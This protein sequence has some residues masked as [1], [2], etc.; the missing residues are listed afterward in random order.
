MVPP[1]AGESEVGALSMIMADDVYLR[2]SGSVLK[3][4]WKGVL[5]A[6]S[7]LDA[8]AFKIK[9]TRVSKGTFS[10]CVNGV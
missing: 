1:R 4:F 8:V 9:L 5:R 2:T 6:A 3:R 7:A 10:G